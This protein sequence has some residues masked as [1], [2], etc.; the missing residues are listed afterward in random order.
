MLSQSLTTLSPHLVLDGAARGGGGKRWGEK[1]TRLRKLERW[2]MKE[3][4]GWI[5]STG[6]IYSEITEEFGTYR[7]L[8][9]V[10]MCPVYEPIS[11]CRLWEVRLYL[12]LHVHT[13]IFHFPVVRLPVSFSLWLCVV[14]R[15]LLCEVACFVVDAEGQN[16]QVQWKVN[17]TITG[18]CI[19]FLIYLIFLFFFAI[20]H[21]S[22]T[23]E[24]K[25]L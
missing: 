2:L 18:F 11:S 14:H 4:R 7:M 22:K 25:R 12:C 16:L 8:A 13:L 10:C 6:A 20:S 23:N 19:S 24:P 17:S 21:V 5:P 3:R 9:C 1:K 15:S